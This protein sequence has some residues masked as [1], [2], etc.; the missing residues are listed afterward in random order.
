MN[1]RRKI[2]REC[3]PGNRAAFTLIELLVVIAIIA[4]LA[5]MLLPALSKAKDRANA[6]NCKGNLKQ[7][8]LAGLM[9]A[10]D[11]ED[12]LP[13]AWWNDN[14]PNSNNFHVLLTPYIKRAGFQAGSTTENSEFAQNVFR[15]AVRMKEPLDNPAIP[16]PGPWGKNPWRISYAMNQATVPDLA[17]PKTMKLTS[18][19]KPT[20]TFFV[21]DLS[22][23][24]NHPSIDTMNYFSV[25]KGQPVYKTGYKHGAAH[26]KGAM[27]L[28]LMD[29]H[30]ENRTRTQTN[31]VVFKWY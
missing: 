5:A 10:D 2:S 14:N 20:D 29:G 16:P 15:C 26:F 21:G 25:Y 9:Y 11:Q 8:G 30:V 31:N 23:D 22:Y 17:S 18:V 3:P 13:Y 1:D 6:I 24:L 28:V 19:T 7:I 4:I 12:R 27:N